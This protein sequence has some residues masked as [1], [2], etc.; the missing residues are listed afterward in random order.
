MTGIS[1]TIFNLSRIVS[2]STVL[3]CFSHA[4][5]SHDSLVI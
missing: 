1:L 4:H 2:I 3:L 5:I